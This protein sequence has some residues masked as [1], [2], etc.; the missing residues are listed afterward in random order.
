MLK[1]LKRWTFKKAWRLVKK[2]IIELIEAQLDELI[3]IIMSDVKKSDIVDKINEVRER[4]RN[5]C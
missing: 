2:A 1:W 5:I 3:E 4:I